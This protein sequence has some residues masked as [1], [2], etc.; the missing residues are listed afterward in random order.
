MMVMVLR[1]MSKLAF[2]FYVG[3]DKEKKLAWLSLVVYIKLPIRTKPLLTLIC[4]A[5]EG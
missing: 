1:S 4:R 5:E 3:A 2:F